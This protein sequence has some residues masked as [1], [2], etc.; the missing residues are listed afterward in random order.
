MIS[1]PGLKGKAT[2]DVSQEQ[3]TV[4]NVGL[5]SFLWSLLSGARSWKNNLWVESTHWTCILHCTCSTGPSPCDKSSTLQVYHNFSDILQLTIQENIF[6]LFIHFLF[7]QPDPVTKTKH[8]IHKLLH[9]TQCSSTIKNQI[10]SLPANNGAGNEF[11]HNL[12][13]SSI[14]GL[15]TSIHKCPGRTKR[16]VVDLWNTKTLHQSHPS[17]GDSKTY[18]VIGYSNM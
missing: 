10:A 8:I 11:F 6:H 9:S 12:I 18:L 2:K 17:H 3:G 1:L 15:Y 7:L 13:G 16:Q 4:L 5:Y 14:D